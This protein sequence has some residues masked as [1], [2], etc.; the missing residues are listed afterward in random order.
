MNLEWLKVKRHLIGQHILL[1]IFKQVQTEKILDVYTSDENGIRLDEDSQFITIEMYVSPT[2]GSPF[3]FDGNTFLNSWC[4][5][6]K[7]EITLNGEL[8]NANGDIINTLNVKSS[9]ELVGDAKICPQADLFYNDEYTAS[10]GITYSYGEFI[11]ENDNKKNALVI[12]M[13]GAGEG[14]T[15]PE[16]AYLGNEVTAFASE[17]F[18]NEFG[19]AYVL[20]PQA[21]TA[22]MDDG[23]GDIANWTHGTVPSLYSEGLFDL[24]DNY[25]KNHPD[26]DPNR[27]IVGGCSNGGFMT[28]EL[29]FNHPDYFAAAYPTCQGFENQYVTDEMVASIIDMPIWFTYSN[30]DQPTSDLYSI[31]LVERLKS[32]GMTNLHTSVFEEVIDSSGRFDDEEGNP[33]VY[34]PHWVWIHLFNNEC[35]DESGVNEW[36]WLSQQVNTSE[37]NSNENTATVEEK[38][39]ANAN[40]TTSIDD[41]I[42]DTGDQV[43]VFGYIISMVLAIGSLV[44]IRKK[45]K[46]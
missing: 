19:G 45:G 16:I 36:E 34:N 42:I 27:I 39:D 33:H 7:L 9:V 2:E 17:E 1:T 44:L 37:N 40:E 14:G 41:S 32:A 21:Q 43:S 6:Y 31:P 15:D 22:W 4:E 28:M 13:H 3:V 24:I 35:F 20:V 30:L 12:W 23:S 25:V 11:P 46:Y 38:N 10:D 29:V 18:Q 26:I 8:R 5:T